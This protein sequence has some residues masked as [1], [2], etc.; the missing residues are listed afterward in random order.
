MAGYSQSIPDMHQC[1][2]DIKRVF[3]CVCVCV[4]VCVFMCVQ[5]YVYVYVCVFACVQVHA[6]VCAQARWLHNVHW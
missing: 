3:V 5:V 1:M 2:R 4:H 6:C